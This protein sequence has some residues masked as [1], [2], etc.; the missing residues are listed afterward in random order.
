MRVNTRIFH[1]ITLFYIN[2]EIL[3]IGLFT[4]TVVVQVMAA[5][6]KNAKADRRLKTEKKKLS[7]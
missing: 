4:F 1:N 7:R 2:L 6:R 3:V 5:P